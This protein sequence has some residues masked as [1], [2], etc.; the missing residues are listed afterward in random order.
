MYAWTEKDNIIVMK[1]NGRKVNLG[2]GSLP[3]LKAINNE[4]AIC[5]WENEDKIHTSFLSL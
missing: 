5:V 4:R 3:I 1:P 2:K